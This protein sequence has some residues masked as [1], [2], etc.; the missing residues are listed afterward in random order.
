MLPQ[1]TPDSIRAAI[2]GF[3]NEYRHTREW[4]GWE[5]NRAHKHALQHSSRLYPPKKIVSL[6]TGV[7]VSDFS[8]GDETNEYLRS[9]GFEVTRLQTHGQHPYDGAGSELDATFSVLKTE[10]EFAIVWD[11]RS[12]TKGTPNARNTQYQQALDIVL[13]RLAV[14]RLTIEE[15]R[16]ERGDMQGSAPASILQVADHSYPWV[17]AHKHDIRKLR[18]ALCKAQASTDRKPDAKGPGNPTKRIIVSITGDSGMNVTEFAALVAGTAETPTRFPRGTQHLAVAVPVKQRIAGAELGNNYRD[19]DEEA[20]VADRDPF[21][22]DPELVER[23][24]RG[25]ATTQNS[26]AQYIRSIG[27]EPRSPKSGEPN[28]DI[29][30][31]SGSRVYVGEVKSITASNEEKQLRLGLG[32]VLRYAYQLGGSEEVVPVLV[33][34]RRP[35]DRSWEDLCSALGVILVWP[36]AFGERL[37]QTPS[38]RPTADCCH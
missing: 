30:W 9:Y 29:A 21:P 34:E 12:G 22:I 31:K 14:A 13:H 16:L 20:A 18:I 1:T 4:H 27:F 5:V 28:F 36:D 7:P 10:G 38:C 15:V 32:Q 17:M 24:V 33:A 37:T 26:L 35:N 6:A 3:D 25:H 2:A 19:A 11:S 23:G 8:G